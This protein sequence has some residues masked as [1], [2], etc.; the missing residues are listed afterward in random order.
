[1]SLDEQDMEAVMQFC[2]HVKLMARKYLPNFDRHE[3]VAAIVAAALQY[4]E[5]DRDQLSRAYMEVMMAAT[6]AAIEEQEENGNSG[7]STTH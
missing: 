1:M 7:G 4:A 6:A 2:G 3:R 5:F